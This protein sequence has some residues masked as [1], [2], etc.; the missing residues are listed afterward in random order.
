MANQK[1]R[2]ISRILALLLVVGLE[3]GAEHTQRAGKVALL[4]HG[5]CGQDRHHR[6]QGE[7]KYPFHFH[8]VRNI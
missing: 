2:G 6:C 1:M 5:S 8:L 7:E 3:F 4:Q